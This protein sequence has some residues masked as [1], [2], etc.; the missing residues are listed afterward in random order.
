MN[1]WKPTEVTNE[2]M[3]EGINVALLLVLGI[4]VFF[5]MFGIW[6]ILQEEKNKQKIK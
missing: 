3:D 4:I 5:V 1:F 2:T 6:A